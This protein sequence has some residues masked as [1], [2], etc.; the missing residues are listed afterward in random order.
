M[1]KQAV[2]V[3]ALSLFLPTIIKG[4]GYSAANAQLLTI[5]VYFAATISCLLVG[6]FADLTGQRG[7]FTAGCYI[8]IFV[9]Y[10][11]AVAPPRFIPGLTYA[12]CFIAA[13]GIYPGKPGPTTEHSNI[14]CFWYVLFLLIL[15]TCTSSYTRPPC[16]VVEQFRTDIKTSRRH[17]NSDG[18]WNYGWRGRFKLLPYF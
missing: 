14:F 6:Y 15:Q 18:I 10:I 17:G 8:T 13:C 4:L 3:Y 16:F 9:G 5:P 11:I 12:S 2:A 7:L 1:S